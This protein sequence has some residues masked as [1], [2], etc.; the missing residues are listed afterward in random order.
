MGVLSK[1]SKIK[2][3]EDYEIKNYFGNGNL[4]EQIQVIGGQIIKSSYYLDGKKNTFT[5]SNIGDS[6]PLELEI[7]YNSGQLQAKYYIEDDITRM[8]YQNGNLE[9]EIWFENRKIIEVVRYHEGGELFMNVKFKDGKA[10][11]GY[12]YTVEGIKSELT[13]CTLP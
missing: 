10:I 5:K 2:D 13:K 9:S 4:E 8:Y 11:K 3:D 6:K 7:Y 12:Q 1:V